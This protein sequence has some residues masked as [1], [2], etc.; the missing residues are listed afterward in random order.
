MSFLSSSFFPVAQY[1]CDI[2]SLLIT[3]VRQCHCFYMLC[4]T[5][6]L[7]TLPLNTPC[8]LSK[9][10]HIWVWL[11]TPSSSHFSLKWNRLVRRRKH[12]KLH[13]LVIVGS[14]KGLVTIAVILEALELIISFDVFS[15]LFCEMP[16]P[17]FYLFWLK[18]ILFCFLFS[19]FVLFGVYVYTHSFYVYMMHIFTIN[20]WIFYAFKF[21]CVLW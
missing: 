10:P 15:T 14:L 4:F 13:V 17:V 7:P 5:C 6:K 16:T 3:Q 12:L 2:L 18:K 1:H 8:H 11:G 21:L 19:V 9:H 20:L